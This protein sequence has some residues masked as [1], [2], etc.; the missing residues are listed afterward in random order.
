MT[1]VSEGQLRFHD[2]TVQDRF[3]I[4]PGS[5]TYSSCDV[6]DS[7]QAKRGRVAP[8]GPGPPKPTRCPEVLVILGAEEG[9]AVSLRTRRGSSSRFTAA[10]ATQ[11]PPEIAAAST[12]PIERRFRV[13]SLPRMSASETEG[14]H[15]HGWGTAGLPGRGALPRF[16]AA[17]ESGE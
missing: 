15:P 16:A 11:S 1:L 13:S 2:G 10:I 14:V 5:W 9:R 3:C 4:E 17:W 12:F 6:N 7:W 8:L